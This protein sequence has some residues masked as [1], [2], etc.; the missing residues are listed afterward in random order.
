M[1]TKFKA[2]DRV[3]YRQQLL[4]KVIAAWQTDIG[5]QMY[6]VQ[7]SKEIQQDVFEHDLEKA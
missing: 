6:S 2:G 4:G 1:S 7:F 3:V 5:Q